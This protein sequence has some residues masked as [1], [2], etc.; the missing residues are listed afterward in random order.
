VASCVLDFGTRQLV[1]AGKVYVPSNGTLSLTA[2]NI[3]TQANINGAHVAGAGAGADVS[4]ISLGDMVITRRIDVS[5]R[6]SVGTITLDCGADIF[7]RG[8]LVARAKGPGTTAPG[9]TVTVQADGTVSSIKLG[10]LDVRGKSTDTAGGQI[11]LSGD[12]GV[13]LG[14]RLDARGVGGGVIAIASTS[15]N[16][17]IGEQVR[18]EGDD[19]PGGTVNISSGGMITFVGKKGEVRS[20]GNPGGTITVGAAGDITLG[21]ISARG[22]SIQGGSVTISS[23]GGT[24][25]ADRKVDVKSKTTAGTMSFSA[26]DLV[27]SGKFDAKGKSSVV[28]SG[29]DIEGTASGNLTANG[30]FKARNGGCIGLSA[31]G[32]LDTTG[33]QFDVPVTGSCP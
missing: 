10:K 9:G 22:K 24:I 32:T 19:S 14:G 1:L 2:G 25:V 23:S 16:V 8:R 29:G 28:G 7:L 31:G 27:L 3:S 6:N 30:S 12:D 18:V 4:L 11:S 33:G 21:K 20:K 13:D 5:G 26:V 17:V 15:G